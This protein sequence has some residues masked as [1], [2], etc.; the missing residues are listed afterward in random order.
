MARH[1]LAVSRVGHAG[2]TSNSSKSGNVTALIATMHAPYAEYPC[3]SAWIFSS[4]SSITIWPKAI[5]W[6]PLAHQGKCVTFHMFLY[7]SGSWKK[8]AEMVPNVAGSC[9]FPTNPD[10]ADILGDTYFDFENLYF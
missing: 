10:L 4:A 3:Q 8:L 1:D 7:F 6:G 5:E 2:I 9:F